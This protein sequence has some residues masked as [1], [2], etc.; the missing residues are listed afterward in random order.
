AL[1]AFAAAGGVTVDA[2]ATDRF[3]ELVGGYPY[4]L[5]VLGS[6]TWNAGEGRGLT[7]DDVEAGWKHAA[8]AVEM[9]YE[10]RLR[11]PTETQR[12]YLE[13]MAALPPEERTSG[14]VA[15]ALGS[16]TEAVG[17]TQQALIDTHG[18]LRR[19]GRGRI[20]FTLP[21]ID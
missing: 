8:S 7:R 12:S 1:T 4:F 5:H 18:V 11:A 14:N 15:R 21:G 3:V 2:D 9:F 10:G 17:S 16:S 6:A 19:V 20:A 13:A